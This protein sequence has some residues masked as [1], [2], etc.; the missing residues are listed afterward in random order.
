MTVLHCDAMW[1]ELY[2]AL[3]SAQIEALD[4]CITPTGPRSPTF[5]AVFAL[6][7]SA[8]L[9]TLVNF[10]V[11]SSDFQRSA[12][13]ALLDAVSLLPDGWLRESL[14][15][16][17]PLYRHM[18]WSLGCTCFYFVIPALLVR[19]VLQ[20]PLSS[21][22]LSPRGF[23]RHLPVYV[24]LFVPVLLAV[25]AVSFTKAFQATY[26]FY[27]HPAGIEDLIIWEVFY[28]LQF[29]A[30]EF[31]FR[32]FLVH[33]MKERLGAMAVFAMVVPYCMIHFQKPMAEA[34]AAILAGTVLGVLSLRT[35]TIW[36]GVAIHSAVA[37]SM[38][39]ASLLQRGWAP[40]E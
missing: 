30:L 2:K 37:V 19:I 20:E 31:F 5:K 7:S 22:G 28:C 13:R 26:P 14:L 1:R 15:G 11:L 17:A 33:A 38:D 8:V 35:N 16:L 23:V 6:V 25:I 18:A 39:V 21:Y 4:R 27:H 29:F 9:L 3:V 12:A 40:G 10:V 34:L 32:G 36:G 24:C